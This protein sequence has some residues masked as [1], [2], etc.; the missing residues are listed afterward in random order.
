MIFNANNYQCSAAMLILHNHLVKM[1]MCM[2]A[3]GCVLKHG[4]VVSSTLC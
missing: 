4:T 2:F 3:Y 1:C